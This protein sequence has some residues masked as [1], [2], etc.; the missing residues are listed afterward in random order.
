MVIEKGF[1]C[2]PL[3]CFVQKE[4]D[5]K[6]ICATPGFMCPW[7][8][9]CWCYFHP[10]RSPGRKVYIVTRFLAV[11]ASGC[12][13]CARKPRVPPPPPQKSG[14]QPLSD[15]SQPVRAHH[16]SSTLFSSDHLASGGNIEIISKRV[17]LQRTLWKV[18]KIYKYRLMAS[19]SGLSAPITVTGSWRR[20]GTS[21]NTTL[22]SVR[23][24]R[25]FFFFLA[26][27][28]HSTSSAFCE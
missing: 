17:R 10:T 18:N 13:T 8:S 16:F 6:K 27:C 11:E 26:K 4:K 23:E 28:V 3:F 19:H 7:K 5:F 24:A 15:D 14:G 2:S 1:T 25:P 22:G 12:V 20:E 9:M 21:P